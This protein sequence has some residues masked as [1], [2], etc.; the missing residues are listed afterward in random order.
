MHL[1]FRDSKPVRV[2]DSFVRESAHHEF[3]LVLGRVVLA[4]PFGPL[5]TLD[6]FC[7]QYKSGRG[8]P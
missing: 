5:A 4:R 8:P 2:F 7:A 3:F 1:I 6:H